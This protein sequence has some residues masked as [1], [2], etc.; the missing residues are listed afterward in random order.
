M[1]RFPGQI[2]KKRTQTTAA[3]EHTHAHRGTLPYSTCTVQDEARECQ[4][5]RHTHAWVS[6]MHKKGTNAGSVAGTHS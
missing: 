1:D 4:G 2:H 5:Y 6:A 3:K